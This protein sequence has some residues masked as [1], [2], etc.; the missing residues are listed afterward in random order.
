M[1]EARLGKNTFWNKEE[2]SAEEIKE[3]EN[4]TPYGGDLNFRLLFRPLWNTPIYRD[5]EEFTESRFK[6]QQSATLQD[7]ADHLRVQLRFVI[8]GVLTAKNEEEEQ[9]ANKRISD[10]IH[11]MVILNTLPELGTYEPVAYLRHPEELVRSMISLSDHNP[12]AEFMEKELPVSLAKATEVRP[13]IYQLIEQWRTKQPK[14]RI[15]TSM[16]QID[17]VLK[18][19]N[20]WYPV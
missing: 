19:V 6:N 1:S 17:E 10:F 20:T 13:V 12:L 18:V 16:D 15:L 5:I 3:R 11:A 4:R 14:E 2:Y 9:R 7:I 8:N